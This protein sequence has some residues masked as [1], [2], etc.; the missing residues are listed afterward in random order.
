MNRSLIIQKL[1][2]KIN[3][4]SYMEIGLGDRHNFNAIRCHTKCSVDPG[5]EECQVTLCKSNV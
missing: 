1:I 2:N 4:K 5:S 3:A